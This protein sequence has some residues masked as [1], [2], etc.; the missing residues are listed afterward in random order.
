MIPRLRRRILLLWL[1]LASASVAA[2]AAMPRHEFERAAMGLPFR[3]VLYAGGDAEAREAADAAFARIDELNG[4]LSD[5]DESSELSRLSASAGTGRW[6]SLSGDLARVLRTAQEASAASAGAF[7]ITVGPLVQLWKRA[8]RQRELP[9]E[10]AL[11]RAREATGWGHLSLRRR[12][13]T[14]Q[15]H[16]ARSAMRLDLGGIAKGYALDEAARVLKGRGCRRFL[17]SGGGDL[18]TGDP[19]PGADGWR[20]EVGISDHPQAPAPVFVS[21]RNQAL[22]TSGDVFQRAEVGGRRYSHIVDPR[23]GIGLTNQSLVTVIAA[24]GMQADWLSTALS[25]L[26]PGPGTRLADDAGTQ[27]L[28]YRVNDGALERWRSRGFYRWLWP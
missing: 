27:Y 17:I 20:I 25:V 10:T 13:G 3:L 26:G 21:L 24:T 6:V 23:T 7:D 15:A 2:A 9:P 12:N 8:R 28:L 11:A 4:V 19:P 18:V 14:W 5:Y 22:A 1:A 16:L